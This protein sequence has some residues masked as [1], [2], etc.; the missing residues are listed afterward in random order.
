LQTQVAES[1]LDIVNEL[2]QSAFFSNFEARN[3]QVAANSAKYEAKAASDKAEIQRIQ[4]EIEKAYS[5][6]QNGGHE[7]S[8]RRNELQTAR[9]T[10]KVGATTAA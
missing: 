2:K 8:D 7:S 10:G 5:T 3:D 9:D 4:L 6:L 1:L